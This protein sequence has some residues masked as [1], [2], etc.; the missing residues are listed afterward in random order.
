[1]VL[2]PLTSVTFYSFS[3]SCSSFGLDLINFS[4]LTDDL[5][6]FDGCY[7]LAEYSDEEGQ[8]T[9]K[10]V[11]PESMW[12]EKRVQEIKKAWDGL[13][14]NMRPPRHERWLTYGTSARRVAVHD[15]LMFFD[16]LFSKNKPWNLSDEEWAAC[17]EGSDRQEQYQVS[18]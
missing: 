5:A 15:S 1:M 3:S 10:F 8:S 11:V 6:A 9:M 18:N 13:L 7:P 17:I 4:L 12:S 2:V 14:R 16:M